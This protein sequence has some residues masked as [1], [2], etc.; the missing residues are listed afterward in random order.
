MLFC[1]VLLIWLSAS[2]LLTWN[3]C[4]LEG[5]EAIVFNSSFA[6]CLLKAEPTWEEHRQ[7]TTSVYPQRSIAFPSTVFTMCEWF[8]V[9]KQ[10]FCAKRKI[11]LK[12]QIFKEHLCGSHYQ[13]KSKTQVEEPEAK[14]HEASMQMLNPILSICTKIIIIMCSFV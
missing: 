5:S 11:V 14:G 8:V 2:K 13:G 7:F 12:H 9:L 10:L 6:L 1:K 3:T 4:V